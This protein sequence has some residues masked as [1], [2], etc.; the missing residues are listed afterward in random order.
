MGCVLV[1]GYVHGHDSQVRVTSAAGMACLQRGQ[2]LITSSS[3]LKD[4]RSDQEPPHP[5]SNAV[6]I[7]VCTSH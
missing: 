4:S 1:L 7:P 2:V 3:T 6:S 5:V